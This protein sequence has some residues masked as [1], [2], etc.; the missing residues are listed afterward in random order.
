MW[1]EDIRIFPL[2]DVALSDGDQGCGPFPTPP[3]IQAPNWKHSGVR[4]GV[5]GTLKKCAGWL[6]PICC[7]GASYYSFSLPRSLPLLFF[8]CSEP[9]KHFRDRLDGLHLSPCQKERWYTQYNFKTQSIHLETLLTC[10]PYWQFFCFSYFLFLLC[11]RF[12]QASKRIVLFVPCF[13]LSRS[14]RTQN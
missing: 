3:S 12:E 11:P 4:S 5:R 13:C 7:F 8:F 9:T 14:K 6:P 2:N 10:V 1:R